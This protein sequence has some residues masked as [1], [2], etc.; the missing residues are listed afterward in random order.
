MEVGQFW[1]L[2]SFLVIMFVVCSSFQAHLQAQLHSSPRVGDL[3]SRPAWKTRSSR[4]K[5]MGRISITATGP[6]IA[7]WRWIV[8]RQCPWRLGC[9]VLHLIGFIPWGFQ[10]L[11]PQKRWMVV[12]NPMKMDDLVPPF[13]EISRIQD[14]KIWMDVFLGITTGDLWSSHENSGRNVGI[15][16]DFMVL[17]DCFWARTS[18]TNSSPSSLLMC[19]RCLEWRLC[20]R[21]GPEFPVASQNLKNLQITYWQVVFHEHLSNIQHIVIHVLDV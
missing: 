16:W 2:R 9:Q 3:C 20:R 13:Q 8:C 11:V 14:R 4:A 6:E 18:T 7:R 12:E 5:R 1:K 10:G 19:V 21:N 17:F 15:R